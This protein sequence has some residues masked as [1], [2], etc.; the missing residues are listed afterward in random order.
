MLLP[1]ILVYQALR[2]TIGGQTADWQRR[3]QELIAA[4][5]TA[6]AANQ[7]KSAFLAAMSHEI[8]TPMGGILG[9]TEL[10]LD[11][12]LKPEQREQ[13]ELV[14]Y[15]AESL[16]SIINDILDFSK[17]EAGKLEL[18][19]IPFELR[20]SLGET[21]KALGFRAQEKGTELICEIRPDVP[22]A[23]VGDPGRIRQIL[24]NL[25]GN[26][27]KFTDGGEIIVRV[28]EIEQTGSETTLQFSVRDTGIGIPP[29]RQEK[30][31]E[32]FSQADGSTAR[33]YGGSGLGL[34][35]CK[36]LVEMMNGRI[37]LDS[38]PGIGSTFYF[39]VNLSIQDVP[40]TRIQS[41]HP[42]ELVGMHALIVD[43]NRTNRLLL[44]ELLS[45]WGMITD[46]AD[47]GAAALEKL[48]RVA[49]SGSSLPLVLLDGYMPDMDGFTVAER[50][51]ED[52]SLQEA[53]IMMLTSA[54][55]VGDAARCRQLGICSYLPKPV[56]QRELLDSLCAVVNH[57]TRTRSERLITRHSLREDRNRRRILVAEDNP[58]NQKLVQRLLEKRGFEVSVA[59]DGIAAVEAFGNS[60]FDLILMDVEMPNMNGWEATSAIRAKEL[61]TNSHIPILALTAHALKGDEEHCLNAGMDAY[62]SKPIRAPELYETIER[63]LLR[64]PI[65]PEPSVVTPAPDVVILQPN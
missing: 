19:S 7:A 23:L 59:E 30:I 62:V 34:S 50:I 2:S 29:E 39:T 3:E 14:R 38:Q 57:A 51:R 53:V 25:V 15:S 52:P 55:N 4:K 41:A 35:I 48:R 49:E 12:E 1:L 46:C 44:K 36:R 60:T 45:R 5:E 33:K 37:W 26:A 56:R 32:A 65:S 22:E 8:R 43:D 13:L 61:G 17:I 21:M 6:E 18:E 9:M 54:A 11:T 16:L 47:S 64:N 28:E 40:A 31:F 20:E 63:L 27:I 58:V 10:T 42:G 24:I